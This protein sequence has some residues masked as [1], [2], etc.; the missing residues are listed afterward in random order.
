[1]PSVLPLPTSVS[2]FSF[3]ISTVDNGKDLLVYTRKKDTTS[4]S[5]LI[6]SSDLGNPTTPIPSVPVENDDDLPI[7]LRKGKRSC[8]NPLSLTL[9]HKKP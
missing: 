9:S 8:T 2:P 5:P 6:V 7:A 3:D 1:M 4:D